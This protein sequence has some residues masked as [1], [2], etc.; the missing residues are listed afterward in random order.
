MRAVY[1]VSSPPD[2]PAMT[3]LDVAPAPDALLATLD[4]HVRDLQEA[5]GEPTAILV[6]PEAYESL[7]TAVA[8][9][10]GRQR[11]D[12]A[13]YQWVPVVVDPFRGDRVC[14][15]PAPRDVSAGVRAERV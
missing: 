13:Q 11:A 1:P 5:G 4:A 15:V 12:L 2:P 10:F 3:V 8:E 7:K 14:V 6:G 9:R